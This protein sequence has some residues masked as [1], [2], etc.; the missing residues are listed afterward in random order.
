MN[1][2]K[3]HIAIL[4]I[5]GLA[6]NM[7]V[8]PYDYPAGERSNNLVVEALISSNPGPQAVRL[9]T[10]R[11][12]YNTGNQYIL[13]VSGAEVSVL[14][15]D[16]RSFPF[17]EQGGGQYYSDSSFS[18][19]GG[20]AYRLRIV[21]KE[22]KVYESNE[23][24]ALPTSEMDKVEIAYTVKSEKNELGNFVD[25]D[26][27]SVK[28]IV[29]DLPSQKNYYLLRMTTIFKVL[30]EPSA[31]QVFDRELGNYVTQPKSC[32]NICW[33]TKP[34]DEFVVFSDQLV[35][36]R[37]EAEIPLTFYPVD[38]KYFYDKVYFEVTQYSLT[39]EAYVF[40]KGL[41]DLKFRQGT[42]FDPAPSGLPGNIFNVDDRSEQVVGYFTVS[43]VTTKGEF[44]TKDF[45][46][47]NVVYTYRYADDC[48]T[49][50]NS[51]T[52]Q[53]AFWR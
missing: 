44:M 10:T 16:G 37:E 32:C 29:N 22:G 21:T 14:D 2:A 47:R 35:D 30:T 11:N 45:I 8:E 4:F 12:I 3:F 1:K 6:L 34:L 5:S 24:T 40:W 39:A 51:T 26:G 7:C 46:P 15:S 9:T 28:A 41:Y 19:V 38:Q 48:R 17:N 52:T 36:G 13:Y 42:L 33:V 50:P 23:E 27:F 18:A 31:Y 25:V 43:D 20:K 53:P 49:L